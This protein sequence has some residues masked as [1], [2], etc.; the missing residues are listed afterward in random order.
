M[1]ISPTWV[2]YLAF[3]MITDPPSPPFS[4]PTI[5]MAE[6]E[7]GSYVCCCWPMGKHCWQYFYL[8]HPSAKKPMLILYTSRTY[9]PRKKKKRRSTQCFVAPSSGPAMKLY[10]S[11]FFRMVSTTRHKLFWNFILRI[12]G[13]QFWLMF[14]VVL[15]RIYEKQPKLFFFFGSSL[16]PPSLSTFLCKLT[17]EA[18]CGSK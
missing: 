9:F 1:T 18:V 13:V 2:I 12:L 15:E 8:H 4:T 17:R 6:Q 7:T 16:P 10:I 11:N 14:V 3:Y 5:K